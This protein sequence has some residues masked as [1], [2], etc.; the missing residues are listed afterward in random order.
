MPRSG[1][2]RRR[3]RRGVAAF[4]A[5]VLLTAVVLLATLAGVVVG[6]TRGM[7]SLASMLAEPQAQ[8]SVL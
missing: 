2:Q 5:T 8:T 7:P 6:A 1:P 4:V 3:W